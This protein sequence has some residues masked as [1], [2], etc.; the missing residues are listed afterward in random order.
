[1]S[2][3]TQNAGTVVEAQHGHIKAQTLNMFHVTLE[4]QDTNSNH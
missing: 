3:G 4:K 1:M 2:E